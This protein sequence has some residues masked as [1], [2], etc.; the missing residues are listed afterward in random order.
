MPALSFHQKSTPIIETFLISVFETAVANE[1]SEVKNRC[2]LVPSSVYLK[3]GERTKLIFWTDQVYSLFQE[4]K[5][6]LKIFSA[7]ETKTMF[8]TLVSESTLFNQNYTLLSGA[9]NKPWSAT[10]AGNNTTSG[11]F[12]CISNYWHKSI[13]VNKPLY[14]SSHE[15]K[16]LRP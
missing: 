3:R 4:I 13:T 6:G 10:E 9:S 8:G 14:F 12:L 15:I 1:E 7:Y 11:M 16:Y 5:I 2:G